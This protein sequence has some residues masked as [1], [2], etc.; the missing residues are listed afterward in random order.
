LVTG[1][2]GLKTRLGHIPRRIYRDLAEKAFDARDEAAFFVVSRKVTVE[3]MDRRFL[4][5]EGRFPR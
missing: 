1:F 4:L 5:L 2:N 3:A